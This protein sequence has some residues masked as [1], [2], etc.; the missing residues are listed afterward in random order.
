MRLGIYLFYGRTFKMG[1]NQLY[2]HK[3]YTHYKNIKLHQLWDALKYWLRALRGTNTEQ[4]P[5]TNIMKL[6]LAFT[7]DLF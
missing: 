5:I 1:K 3:I 2:Y 4:K 7:K 6:T